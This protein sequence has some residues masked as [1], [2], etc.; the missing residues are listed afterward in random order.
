MFHLH[1]SGTRAHSKNKYGFLKEFK[2]KVP[3]KK[4]KADPPAGIMLQFSEVFVS[5]AQGPEFKPSTP[6]QISGHGSMYL[7]WRGGHRD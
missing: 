3:L 2:V 7:Q 6:T 1:T 5:Q 4:K